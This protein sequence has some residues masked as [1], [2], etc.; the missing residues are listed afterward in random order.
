MSFEEMPHTADIKIRAHAPTLET[1]FSEACEALMQ[2]MYGKERRAVI[3]AEIDV[4]SSDTESLLADF[5]SELLFRSEVD[6]MVFSEVVVRITG[7]HLH[8]VMQGEPFDRSRHAGGTEVKGI[9][10]SGMSVT[11]DTNGY[12]LEIL[13][14]V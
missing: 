3:S 9:S 2:V 11:Q 1:L 14:D 7:T 8:A 4:D 10:Y 12:M 13:F 6:G 5:L